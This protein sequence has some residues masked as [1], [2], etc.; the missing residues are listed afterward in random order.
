MA[1]SGRRP[2]AAAAA[3]VAACMLLGAGPH[4][5]VVLHAI[6][7]AVNGQTLP[8]NPAPRI[9]GG[10][11]LVPVAKTYAALGI[12][13]QRVGD[14]LTFSAPGQRVTLRIGSAHAQIGD[15]PVTMDAPA[16]TIGG[17]TYVPLRFVA[18]SLG[19]QAAFD[20]RANR[21][22]ITSQLVGRNPS[23]EQHASGGIQLV[24]TVSA[25]DLNSNPA[26]VT[27]VRAGNARTVGIGSE[28]PVALQDVVTRTSSPAQLPELHVGD[29]VSVLIRRDGRVSSVVARYASRTGTIAAVSP[30]LFV[31]GDGL[32]VVPDKSTQITLNA[33]PA[34]LEDLHVGDSVTIRSNPDTNEKRQIIASRAVAAA[35]AAA[36]GAVTI[37]SFA[38]TGKSAL[39]GGDTLTVMLR[40]P[41]EGRATYDIGSF[42]TRLPMTEAPAGVY[43]ARYTIPADMNIGPT[44]LVGHLVVGGTEAPPVQAAQ[45]VAVST[46]PP[47]IVEVAP[48]NGL[49]VNNPRP[50]IYATFRSPTEVGIN[51]SSATIRV[52]GLDVTPSATRTPGFIT[53]SP[54]VP[55]GDGPVQVTVQVS[56]RAGNVQARSWSF[57]IRSH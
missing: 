30:S 39:R 5:Q 20:R 6:A 4:P 40:G 52:N 54:G 11:V 15:I 33:Q 2:F 25:V 45:L 34:S 56:D 13:V 8:R 53:Y 48:S 19:T 14:T 42:V 29:A 3:L 9:V 12:G 46:A 47:Q 21:V 43:T 16:S 17:V 31:L 50:S 57:T 7:I 22:E 35:P 24:G 28:V 18:Q 49:T 51:T 38:V 36:P 55:L 37:A 23:L 10:R 44:A 1:L 32:M 26:S 27:V 41:A